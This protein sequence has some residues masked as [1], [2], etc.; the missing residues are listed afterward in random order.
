MARYV[1]L[2]RG[3]NVGGKNK[4]PMAQLRECL[5]RLGLTQVRTLIASGNVVASSPKGAKALQGLIEAELPREFRL[6]TD[7]LRVLVLTEAKLR[8]VVA[9]RPPGFGE[10]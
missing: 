6:D 10:Q 2:L 3:I 8:A 5:E 1:I 4:V 9:N 7:L